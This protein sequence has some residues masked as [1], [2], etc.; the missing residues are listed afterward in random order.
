MNKTLVY[1]IKVELHPH[2]ANTGAM[3]EA[4]NNVAGV[5]HVEIVGSSMKRAE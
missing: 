2:E 1:T 3:I 4:L 5:K